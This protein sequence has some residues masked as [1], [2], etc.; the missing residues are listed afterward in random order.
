MTGSTESPVLLTL[1]LSPEVEERV[2]DW[3]L[4]RDRID[5]FSAR[6]GHGHGG[7]HRELSG[8]EQVAGRQARRFIEI[9]TALA[10]ARTLVNDLRSDFGGAGLHYWISP[11]IEGGPLDAPARTDADSR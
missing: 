2:V 5:G 7:A 6:V 8:A 9:Q 10:D 11:L 3:L 4:A 1:V